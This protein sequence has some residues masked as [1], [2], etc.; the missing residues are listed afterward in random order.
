MRDCLLYRILGSRWF[1]YLH[2]TSKYLYYEL[3]Y[4]IKACFYD[5]RNADTSCSN[6]KH[7][8]FSTLLRIFL[9]TRKPFRELPWN[10]CPVLAAVLFNEDSQTLLC[11]I[12]EDVS[13]INN[14][15][16]WGS[17][18]LPRRSIAAHLRIHCDLD[19][20]FFLSSASKG[21]SFR[22]AGIMNR[23]RTFSFSSCCFL[24]FLC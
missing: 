16:P 18:S 19:L 13:I 1:I 24:N 23:N 3:S 6:H 7:L 17:K 8:P 4:N 22:W 5:L 14:D 9:K 11:L 20:I 2:T 10:Y 21:R 15:N 12:N